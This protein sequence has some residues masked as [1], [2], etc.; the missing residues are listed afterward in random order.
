MYSTKHKE[1]V[2]FFDIYDVVTY[3]HLCSESALSCESWGIDF[4]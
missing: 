1:F 3:G 2:L 4:A